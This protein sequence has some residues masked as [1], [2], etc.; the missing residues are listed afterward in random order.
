MWLLLLVASA[1]AVSPEL[2]SVGGAVAQRAAAR[3]DETASQPL[4]G[5]LGWTAP[6]SDFMIRL[7]TP[8]PEITF[9][10]PF[11]LT[12]LRTWPR[13]LVPATWDDSLLAPLTV[14]LEATS[15]RETAA[16]VEETRRFRAHAFVRTG[17]TLGPLTFRALPEDGGAPL[18]ARSAPLELSIRSSL[19]AG[20]PCPPELPAG[21]L[22]EPAALWPWLAALATATLALFFVRFHRPRPVDPTLPG[23]PPAAA[24]GEALAHIARLRAR[25]PTTPAECEAFLVEAAA[26]LRNYVAER[27]TLPAH[28]RTT[29]ELVRLLSSIPVCQEA[30]KHGLEYLL[31]TCDR[32]KFARAPLGCGEVA[33]LL[34][35]A[36]VF[37]LTTAEVTAARGPA[38]AERTMS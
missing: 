34:D 27:F 15:R 24:H 20:L 12:V 2:T 3:Q 11:S 33:G 38:L 23:P 13:D 31:T 29:P 1:G 19:P 17:L 32:V 9:G 30:A 18:T 28:A 16:C 7:T 6:R 21:P 35:A 22:T 25:M 26:I 5:A 10:Q 14:E 37:V 8:S 36:Q 4:D